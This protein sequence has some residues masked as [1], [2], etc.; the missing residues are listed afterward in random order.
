MP[1]RFIGGKPAQAQ[2][3]VAQK[4]NPEQ[5]PN[6]QQQIYGSGFQWLLLLMIIRVHH[7]DGYI[8]LIL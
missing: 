1:K 8:F 7:I 2:N 3:T 5:V 6:T 4:T